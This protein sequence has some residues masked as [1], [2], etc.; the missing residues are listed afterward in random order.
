M[1]WGPPNLG[2]WA[3]HDDAPPF[4]RTG[5]SAQELGWG[6]MCG[7]PPADDLGLCP[8]HRAGIIG[9]PVAVDSPVQVQPTTRASILAFIKRN[10][11]GG[12]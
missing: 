3:R 1:T 8:H 9:P 2:C 10:A 4:E 7:Q 11:G 5:G 12:S 6:F